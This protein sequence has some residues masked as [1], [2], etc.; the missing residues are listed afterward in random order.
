[1]DRLAEIAGHFEPDADE[2]GSAPISSGQALWLLAEVRR[3][4]QRILNYEALVDNLLLDQGRERTQAAALL[5]QA[6]RA[7]DAA[8]RHGEQSAVD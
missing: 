8:I 3:L 1:M 5:V 6:R 2:H 4:R 7:L